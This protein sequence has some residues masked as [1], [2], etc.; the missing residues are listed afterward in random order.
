MDTFDRPDTNLPARLPASSSRPPAPVFPR[1][2]AV[3]PATSS[4]VNA[5]MILHGLGRHWWR[6]LL[7]WLVISA[8]VAVAIYRFV[9]PTYESFAVLKVQPNQPDLF[10]ASL[11]GGGDFRGFKPYLETQVNLIRGDTVLKKAVANARV[12]ELPMITKSVDP[13][14]DLRGQ[15]DVQIVPNTYLIRVALSSK[16]PAEATEIVRAVSDAY[17]EEVK[18]SSGRSDKT[19]KD[20]LESY[21]KELKGQIETKK[22]GLVKLAK[23]GLVKVG[24]APANPNAPEGSQASQLAFET[25]SLEQYNRTAERLFETN[26][27][28][29]E[30]RSLLELKDAE[31]QGAKSPDEEAQGEREKQLLARITEEFKHDPE[32]VSLA[33]QIGAVN[34]E[35]DHA[36]QV[37]RKGSDPSRAAARNRL[38]T[39]NKRYHELWD[40]RYDEIRQRLLVET[41]GGG[42]PQSLEELKT[43]VA[44]LQKSREGLDALLKKMDTEKQRSNSDAVEATFL[45]DEVKRLKGMHDVVNRKLEQL[46][47]EKEMVRVEQAEKASVPKIPAINKRVRY[48]VIAP[49]GVLFML[50]GV[51]LLF[52]IRAERVADPDM[53][54]TRVQSEVYA[55][56]P[57]PR[58]RKLSGPVADDQIDR[59][60]QRLDHLRFAVC[61][62]HPE[63]GVGRCVL[64][65]SAIGGEGKTTLAAQLAARCGNAGISTLLIDADIRRGALS[66]LLD[67]PEDKGLTDVLEEKA[68][69]EESVIPVQGGTFH[70][71]AAGTPV[72]DT[73]R[74]FQ[75]RN[76]GLLIAR[77]RQMYELI[78]I[79]SPPILPV[80]DGLMLGRWTDGAVLAARYDVSRSPQVERARRQL[81]GAG[82]PVL[83]TVINGMRSSESYYGRYTYSR[84]RTSPPD[85]T[86]TI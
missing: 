81:D 15:L 26:L 5:R 54:S 16:D 3:S 51:F 18:E 9:E 2:M 13:V 39:L 36:K 20:K 23:Q 37:A 6:I 78:I 49:V 27:A 60:I 40:A 84:Q 58:A 66:P 45:D 11:Q 65:T 31:L 35:L 67:V 32:V 69:L 83:G 50:L 33:E 72:P 64:I 62:G 38:A 63:P 55:L 76:F 4:P 30:A 56:P 47:F 1:E 14:A 53:L 17:L 73:S 77:L 25:Y 61:G 48:A 70:L 29:I 57:L 12:V 28:L 8:P 10:G 42:S 52:E 43:K 80:P 74:I 41:A 59:F 22:D 85:S 19:L 79:D 34:E 86:S 68:G 46:N 24:S 82:I 75:G 71:L 44:T 7:L 21:L